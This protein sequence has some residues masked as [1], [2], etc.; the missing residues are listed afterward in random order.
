MTLDDT[1]PVYSPGTPRLVSVGERGVTFVA[2]L[3]EPGRLRYVLQSSVASPPTLD[4]VL[5][6]EKCALAPQPARRTRT[7]R[8]ARSRS[9]TQV[10]LPVGNTAVTEYVLD[11]IQGDS[12]Y[13]LYIAAS[14]LATPTPNTK[15]R[16]DG[17]SLRTAAEH[18]FCPR[19]GEA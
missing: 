16:V 8:A 18:R 2:T 7:S 14:D 4:D 5:S 11:G 19:A 1:P 9:S 13:T 12:S 3:N 6:G 17:S 15:A 10:E